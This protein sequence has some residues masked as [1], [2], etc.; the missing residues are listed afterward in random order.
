MPYAVYRNQ[1]RCGFAPVNLLPFLFHWL[2]QSGFEPRWDPVQRALYFNTQTTLFIHLWPSFCRK[3]KIFEKCI[4]SFLQDS[5]CQLLL[6]HENA[7]ENTCSVRLH[8]QEDSFL[9]SPQ[10]MLRYRGDGSRLAESLFHTFTESDLAIQKETCEEGA[11]LQLY[12]V[13]PSLPNAI[14]ETPISSIPHAKEN[15]PPVET[16]AL[17]FSVGLLRS[18]PAPCNPLA[19]WFEL[20]VPLWPIPCTTTPGPRDP[21]TEPVSESLR[22]ITLQPNRTHPPATVG[23]GGNPLPATEQERVVIKSSLQSLPA[24]PDTKVQ[25]VVGHIVVKNLT[26]QTLLQY[27]LGLF[28]PS[29]LSMQIAGPFLSREHPSSALRNKQEGATWEK[30][31]KEV[32]DDSLPGP[33]IWLQSRVDTSITPGQSC[34]T[35]L[36]Q[37]RITQTTSRVQNITTPGETMEKEEG[38]PM[39]EKKPD[40]KEKSLDIHV[41]ANFSNHPPRMIVAQLAPITGGL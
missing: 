13:V 12:A 2:K 20:P 22:P 33:G 18:L 34:V 17:L 23:Q 25:Y 31:P 28:C 39:R 9:S 10:L 7:Q 30:I 21:L 29:A 4:R 14:L 41:Y 35:P 37:L 32:I 16:I 1:R 38:K 11:M 36:L 5:P 26:N 15:T 8:I 3:E 19:Q 40:K 27:K 24:S 6:Y